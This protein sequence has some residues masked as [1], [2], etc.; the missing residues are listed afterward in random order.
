MAKKPNHPTIVLGADHA[1]YVLKETL[2]EF[3][4]SLGYPI[5]DKGAFSAAPVDYPDFCIPAAEEV[6]KSRGRKLGIVIGGTG[7]G[8]SMAANKVKGIRCAHID[9]PFTARMSRDH[10]NANMIALGGRT[11]TKDPKYT[12]RLVRIWLETPFS[13]H[14]RHVRR[15]KKIAKYETRQK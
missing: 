12:K 2:K 4:L 7:L 1:G 15:L 5:E 6:A 11:V 14:R 10:N 8:E 3:L 13:E 9:D